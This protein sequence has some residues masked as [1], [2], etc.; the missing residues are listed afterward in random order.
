ML[1]REG[2]REFRRRLPPGWSASEP[3]GSAT[4]TT[5]DV[6]SPDRRVGAVS[7]ETQP[8]LAPKGV[9]PLIEAL[10]AARGPA[11]PLVIAPYL[12]DSTRA[13][14]REGDLGY[15]DLTGNTRIVLARPGLFI[16]TEGAAQDPDR[17][18]RPARSLRG[19]KAGR[20]ARAL[21][22]LKLPP[23][24]R[25]LAALTK[26]DP[27][28]VSRVLSLLDAEALITR[29]RRGRIESVDWPGLLR[30][31]ATEAPLASR[32]TLR[33]FLEPRGLTALQR[34]LQT[35]E[36][37]YAITGSLVAAALAPLAPARLATLW[38][39][40]AKAIAAALTVRPADAGAN[41]MLVETDDD[42]VFEAATQRDGLWYASPSQ[43]AVDLLT[44]PG[45]GPQEGEELIAWMQANEERWRR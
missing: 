19:T 41:V 30:R 33:T 8:R 15:L 16:E 11:T 44:S 24:V 27:G 1:I 5:V 12:S 4:A 39:R 37:P 14:L 42:D 40:D 18:E 7:L 9:R 3:R 10:A 29:G 17:E 31:W 36:E 21:V 35:V 2:L 45:R 34:R 25:D 26:V 38:V 20:V 22:E 23:G 32:G 13:G 28:Y 43:A 6:T